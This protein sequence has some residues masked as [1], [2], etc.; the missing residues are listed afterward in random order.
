MNRSKRITKIAALAESREGMARLELA[1]ASRET[2]TA[3]MALLSVFDQC[4]RAAADSTSSNPPA[5]NTD[6]LSV[7]FGRALIESGWLAASACEEYL[8]MASR[9][10]ERKQDVWNERR[11][12]VDAL[13]RLV[14]RFK[15]VDDIASARLNDNELDDLINSRSSL[16]GSGVSHG[17]SGGGR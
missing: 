12:T 6:Q 13:E 4:R 8:Q 14:D 16:V 9:L 7:R 11:T 15:L 2:A 3:E 17:A 10:E 1:V 5:D